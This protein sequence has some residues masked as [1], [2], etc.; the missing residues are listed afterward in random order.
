MLWQAFLRKGGIKHVPEML[1]STAKTIEKFLVKPLVAISKEEKF[2][3]RWNI[4]G[5]W[6]SI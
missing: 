1:S 5:R 6:E 4:S 2:S 3:A